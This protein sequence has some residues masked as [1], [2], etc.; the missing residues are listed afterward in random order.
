MNGELIRLGDTTVLARCRAERVRIANGR[1]EGVEVLATTESGQVHAV[2]VRCPVVVTA[3][4][5]LSRMMWSN[6]G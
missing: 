5:A 3:A 6:C 1:V 4:G 2:T